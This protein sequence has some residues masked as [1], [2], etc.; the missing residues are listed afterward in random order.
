MKFEIYKSYT[1]NLGRVG[2]KV[3]Y[4]WRL[5]ARNGRIIACSGE[6][7]KSKS[8]CIKMIRKIRYT[9]IISVIPHK[10]I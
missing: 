10:F 5:K 8:H 2:L 3:E 6:G 9:A 4:R 1:D 7:Y